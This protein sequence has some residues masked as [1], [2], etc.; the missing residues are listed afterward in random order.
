LYVSGSQ[1]DDKKSHSLEFFI[2]H[3]YHFCLFRLEDLL[4]I[5]RM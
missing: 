1:K 2:I 3:N 5:T 4:V